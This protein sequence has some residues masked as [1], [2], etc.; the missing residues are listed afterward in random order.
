MTLDLPKLRIFVA[1]A[2]SGSFTRAAEELDLR[3]PTVSQQIQVLERGLRTP[4]FERLGR[5]VQL[6]PAGAAL[7]PYAERILALAGEAEAT[8]REAAGLAARTLRL[9]AGNTLATYVLPDLLARLRWEQPEVQV[10]VQ[11]GNT[12]QLIAAVVDS[13][14]EL[15]LVGAPLSHPLLAIHAFLRD[16]LVV[17]VPADDHWATRRAVS[18][19]ELRQRTLLLREEGSALQAAVCELLRDHG[20]A[21][22]RTI[23]LGNLEAIK[24]CVEAALGISIVPELAVRREV[25]DGTLRAL[26]LADVQ[27]RRVFNYIHLRGRP[28][29]PAA[30]AFITLLHRPLE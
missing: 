15:A 14:V 25:R 5:R 6:T 12:E 10:Q 11:V 18:L 3:Q 23:T 26:P 2:R 7:L 19:G 4:L 30:R 1:V 8:T 22:E 29:S 16:D 17:I 13:R 27:V 28:L 9:G 21:P 24:R 20:I